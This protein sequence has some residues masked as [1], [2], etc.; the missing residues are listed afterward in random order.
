[1]VNLQTLDHL[2]HCHD[3]REGEDPQCPFDPWRKFSDAHVDDYVHVDPTYQPPRFADGIAVGLY[4]DTHELVHGH[5]L[6]GDQRVYAN[7][8]S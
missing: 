5:N 4:L 8:D 3:Y 6:V 2:C 7:V 1:M